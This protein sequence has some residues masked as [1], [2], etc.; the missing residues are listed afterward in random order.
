MHLTN[1]KQPRMEAVQSTS[2]ILSKSELTPDEESDSKGQDIKELAGEEPKNKPRSFSKAKLDK[3]NFYK[4][5]SLREVG[6][7]IQMTRLNGIH[8]LEQRF[9]ADLYVFCLVLIPSP[10]SFSL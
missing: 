9:E 1:L 10:L 6:C 3:S 7:Q 2:V 8:T 5:G 4:E